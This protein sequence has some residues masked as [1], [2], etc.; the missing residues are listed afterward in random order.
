[1]IP[2]KLVFGAKLLVLVVRVFPRKVSNSPAD[3]AVPPQLAAV[4]QL[5]FALLPPFQYRWVAEISLLIV[6]PVGLNVAEYENWS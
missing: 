6:T 4:D 5:L 1:M 2:E 3:G